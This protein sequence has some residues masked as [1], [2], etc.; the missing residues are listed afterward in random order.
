MSDHFADEKGN[1]VPASY[2][3]M[4]GEGWPL[5]M[6]LKVTFDNE[7]GKTKLTIRHSGF[8]D[9]ENASMADEGWNQSLDK[10]A[11]DLLSL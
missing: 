11:E 4:S 8:P 5:E 1:I 6:R 9:K 7:A 2:Y 10:L 3:G